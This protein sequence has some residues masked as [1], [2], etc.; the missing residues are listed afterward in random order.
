MKNSSRQSILIVDDQPTNIKILFEL[1][2]QTGFRVSVA[3][4]GESA[5]VKAEQAAPD[6]ILLDVMM[7]GMDGY[8]TCRRLKAQ[9]TTREI[10]VIFLS[11]LDQALNKVEAFAVGGA[12]Y[13]TKPFQ[14]AEVLARV[15]HQLELRMAKA[16][17]ALLNAQLEERIQQRTL[18]LV[19]T[20]QFLAKQV[21]QRQQAEAELRHSA[22][23]DVLTDLPNR[24]LFME[25]LDL[26][27]R[28]V[29]RSGAAQFAVLFIDLDRFKAINDTLGHQAGDQ[30]LILVAERLRE[31]V[32]ETDI[33]ARLGGDEFIVLVDPIVGPQDALQISERLVQAF[34]APFDLNGHLVFTTT[35]IGIA[36]STMMADQEVDLLRNADIAM[37]RAKAN[38]KAR[39]EVFDQQMYT[40]V[41]SK[42]QLENELRQAIECQELTLYYQPVVCLSSEK[43][44]GFEA[45][46]RWRHPDRGLV[47]PAEF[48]PLAEEMGLIVAMGEWVLRTAC[49]QLAQWQARFAQATDLSMSVNLSVKQ[50]QEPNFLQTVDRVL[51]ETG[52]CSQSLQ[53]EL[54]ESMLMDNSD[55]LVGLLHQLVDRG[56]EL[57]IDDFGTGYSSLSYLPRFPIH[58]IK[59]DQSFIRPML[60]QREN[61]QIVETIIHLA[62]QLGIAAIA[63]GIETVEH[64]HHLKLQHCE[65]GQG[66]LFAKPLSP[67]EA[68][69]LMMVNRARLRSDLTALECAVSE[70]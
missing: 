2:Q 67:E 66:Y 6:L 7:P 16:E 55:A 51:R 36:L 42:H 1:L 62:H 3:K 22:L 48:I 24:T 52:I 44:T 70:S 68:A 39:F 61:R 30:L 37:Y 13:I 5:L 41:L 69:S 53:L 32:R 63:E 26:A 19:T 59:V 45:L 57:S 43:L 58:A 25:H 12:D 9:A 60:Q 38:G 50:L 28:K 64:L 14:T 33:L 65:K 11:A 35:S 49:Q 31:V 27:Q 10:P 21:N 20:N 18:Q 56:I 4:S 46:I 29:K 8:Q 17:I 23:H 34:E 40:Q 54:T 15:Q 47:S